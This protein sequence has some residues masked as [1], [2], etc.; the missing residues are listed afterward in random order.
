MRH[1]PPANRLPDNVRAAIENHFAR[2]KPGLAAVSV[3]NTVHAIRSAAPDCA[4]SD[5][6]LA[7]AVARHAIDNGYG[8]HFDGKDRSRVVEGW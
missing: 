5:D 4:L 3:A 6:I 8:V 7:D 2:V 1:D